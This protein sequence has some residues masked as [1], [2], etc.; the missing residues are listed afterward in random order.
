MNLNSIVVL[1][2]TIYFSGMHLWNYRKNQENNACRLFN[3]PLHITV[4]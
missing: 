1:N 4:G 2:S 3:V